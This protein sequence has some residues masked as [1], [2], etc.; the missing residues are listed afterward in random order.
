MHRTHV[1][2]VFRLRDGL[3]GSIQM[4]DPP[5]ADQRPITSDGTAV[6]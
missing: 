2:W 5:S 3:I 6:Q 4:F 1:L